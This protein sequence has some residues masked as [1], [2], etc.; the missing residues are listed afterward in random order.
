MHDLEALR[1]SL[2][3]LGTGAVTL[4]PDVVVG[5][6]RIWD[7][8]DGSGEEQMHGGKIRGDRIENARWNPPVLTFGIERHGRTVMGSKSADVHTWEVDLIKATARLVDIKRRQLLP[9]AK[10]LD[11]RPIADEIA[12]L[13]IEGLDDPRLQWSKDRSSVRVLTVECLGA[14]FKQTMTDR[15]KRFFAAI[16]RELLLNGW[17][18][19]LQGGRWQRATSP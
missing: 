13:I 1:A 8:L 5:L 10:K 12:M 4:T 17:R 9:P 6:K 18:R 2:D 19:S 14:A 3:A 7:S 16:D 15:R 11:V